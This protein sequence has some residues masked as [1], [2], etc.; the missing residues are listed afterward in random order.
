MTTKRGLAAALHSG[1]PAF[2]ALPAYFRANFEP[3]LA[4]LLRDAVAAGQIRDDVPA[5]MLLRAVSA[6][7]GAADEAE[8]AEAHVMLALMT[9]GLLR[10]KDRAPDIE[11]R[12]ATPLGQ[13]GDVTHYS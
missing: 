12:L 9:D 4:T 8:P 7:A 6:L 2:D 11:D 13:H 3:A 10:G 1:D 5:W